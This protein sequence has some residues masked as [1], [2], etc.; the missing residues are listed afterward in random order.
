MIYAA[1]E[2]N[3]DHKQLKTIFE[4]EVKKL[5]SIL[6]S[7]NVVDYKVITFLEKN[8]REVYERIKNKRR[9]SYKE[10]AAKTGAYGGLVLY[11]GGTIASGIA[12]AGLGALAAVVFGGAIVGTEGGYWMAKNKYKLTKKEVR[13]F[14]TN[15][16]LEYSLGP[17]DEEID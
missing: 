3:W 9:T 6:N 11:T 12:T 2:F 16:Y 17:L 13:D 5:T 14:A 15:G 4:E 10:I 1:C 8:K 7:I